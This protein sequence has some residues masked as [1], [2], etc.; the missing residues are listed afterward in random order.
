[1]KLQTLPGTSR[2]STF[3][4]LAQYIQCPEKH[5]GQQVRKISCKN[6]KIKEKKIKIYQ[7]NRLTSDGHQSYGNHAI[8]T[9]YVYSLFDP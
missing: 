7:K 8:H 3:W 1:M 5:A 2:L 6:G 4:V 9:V